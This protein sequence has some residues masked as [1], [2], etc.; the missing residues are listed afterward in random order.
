MVILTLTTILNLKKKRIF[1]TSKISICEDVWTILYKLSNVLGRIFG[2]DPQ[3]R[4]CDIYK[5]I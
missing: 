2:L 3:L 4:A 5:I 1:T